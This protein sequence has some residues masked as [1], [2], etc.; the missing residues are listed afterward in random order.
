MLRGT[1]GS[2]ITLSVSLDETLAIVRADRAQ[3]EQVILN[4][5]INARDAMPSG[6]VIEI[7][8][9]NCVLTADNPD[10]LPPGE[11][12][13]LTVADN[14]IGIDPETRARIF[15]PFF[16]T[17]GRRGTRLRLATV[18][19]IVT[20]SG[21]AIRCE[22]AKGAGTRFEI[23]LPKTEDVVAPD[24]VKPAVT[25][26][27]GTERI[28]VVEDDPAVRALVV[29]TLA[30]KGYDV[31]AAEDGLSALDLVRRGAKVD[32]LISDVRMPRMNGLALY[33]QIQQMHPGVATLLISGDSAPEVPRGPDGHQPRFL[34]KS[35]RGEQRV[36]AA[37]H[38]PNRRVYR[39]SRG[40][41][42]A[43][44]QRLTHAP[45]NRPHVDRSP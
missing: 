27:G 43:R 37:G 5:A 12:V 17:K 40:Q 18:Y 29:A 41:D 6:G 16:T 45:R 2:E 36:A 21:G 32:L 7:A 25:L 11:Y 24:V 8:T 19:G 26:A 22:S 3:L 14:G 35:P 38:Q 23:V 13:Q 20:Q 33:D 1:I 15:E 39:R 10:A 4:L 31:A 42:G 9:R 30:R 34:Q 28:L 44:R